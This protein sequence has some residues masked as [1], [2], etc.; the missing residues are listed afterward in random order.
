MNMKYKH[1]VRLFVSALSLSALI[2]Q[3]GPAAAQFRTL[4]KDIFQADNDHTIADTIIYH[5]VRVNGA[6]T[7]LP[8]NSTN[9]GE[10]FDQMLKL[11]WKFWDN[12]EIDTNGV[13]Y[14]MNHQ[15][16]KAE[17]DGRGIGGDQVAMGLSS[18]D[19]YYNYTGNQALIDN[20]KYQA[21]YYL[22]HSLAAPSTKWPNIPYPYNTHV[23]S[24][25]YDGDMKA[26]IGVLQPD[27]AG[28]LGFELV[29]LY[30]K[31]GETKY[32][33]AAVKIANTMAANVKAGDIRH[34][35]WPFK[36]NAVTGEIPDLG[37]NDFY[38]DPRKAIYT[39]N[40]VGTLEL[41]SELIKLQKGNTVSHKKAF[42]V[43]LNWM[44][45]YPEVTND[46]GPFFEDVPG[47]SKTQI[48]AT[49][50]A[51][52][53]MENPELYTDWKKTVTGI[54]DWVHRTF[55]NKDWSK[56]GVTITNEQTAY[57]VPGNSHTA[58]Q[59]SMELLYWAL[60]GDTTLTRNAVRE[61]I[62]A[63]YAVDNDGKNYYPTNDVWMTDGY[64]DFVRHYI[65]A[66]AAAPELA[67][68][69]ADHMLRTSSVVKQITY[70]PGKIVYK[71]YDKASRDLFRLT[72]KPGSIN[73]DGKKLPEVTDRNK[74]GWYWLP[75]DKGGILS[76]RKKLG[77]AVTIEK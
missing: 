14:Y 66:M 32:L 9:Y 61:L 49:T 22:A 76:I 42:A 17:H 71:T 69:D 59:G 26:P 70:A 19:L 21:D 16:W 51:M 36:V 5:R 62:W 13:K 72:Y 48:N 7:L 30:K 41:F 77:N 50:Y 10:S 20:A 33:E 57:P 4:N 68:S 75:L 12:M 37:V 74:E 45:T 58:R 55:N 53:V 35:P 46:W 25:I 73:V 67:P 28:S 2:M 24:G 64:G 31:T 8:W 47:Y 27:K 3:A 23:E 18:W 11:V 34:S 40:W 60:T 29:R 52:Y 43:A 63:T 15:V 1:P 54:F 6:G 65:R 38:K 56:Y 44:K 39:T